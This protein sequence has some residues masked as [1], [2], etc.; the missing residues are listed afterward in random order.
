M[1]PLYCCQYCYCCCCFSA[2]KRKSTSKT[3]PDERKIKL[4]SVKNLRKSIDDKEHLGLKNLLEDHKF[5]GCVNEPLTLVQHLT[6]LYLVNSQK[7]S[8]ELF[9][10]ILLFKFGNFGYI[11]LSSPAPI[12]ELTLLALDSPDSGW[13]P[14]DGDKT[15]L[16]KYVVDLLSS[17]SEMLLD[18]FSLKINEQ[19]ELVSLPLLL[20]KYTPNLNGLPMFLLKL[21]TEVWNFFFCIRV[22]LCKSPFEHKADSRESDKLKQNE[23]S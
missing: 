12:Y 6:R 21:A 10:Q 8:E 16:A 19:N 7:L 17:K 3:R 14:S 23:K 4:T 9:Y 22:F 20:D 18:Y 2:L 5:V 1:S 11:N 15:D 13:I